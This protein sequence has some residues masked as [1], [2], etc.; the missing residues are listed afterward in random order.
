LKQRVLEGLLP[1]ESLL[2]ADCQAFREKVSGEIGDEFAIAYL[3]VVDG[4]DELQLIGGHPRS[5]PMQHLKEDQ[6]N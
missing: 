4:V 2:L 3:L 5:L 6:A 1:A